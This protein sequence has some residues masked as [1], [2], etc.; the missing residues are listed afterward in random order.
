MQRLLHRL[1]EAWRQRL[2]RFFGQLAKDLGA[3]VRIHA[4]QD[5]YR[6]R[7]GNRRNE[8]CRLIQMRLVEDLHR[9]LHWHRRQHLCSNTLVETVQRLGGVRRTKAHHR[10]GDVCWTAGEYTARNTVGRMAVL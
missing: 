10:L 2:A 3:A 4:G 5:C 8:L 7:G 9:R 6:S 1:I